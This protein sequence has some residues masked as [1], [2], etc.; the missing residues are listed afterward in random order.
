MKKVKIPIEKAIGETIPH[1]LTKIAPGEGFKGVLFKK[2]HVINKEDIPLLKSIGKNYIYKLIL[3]EDEIHEDDFAKILSEKIAGENIEYDESPSEG[4]IMFRAG[5]DGLFKLNKQRVVKLN[6]IAETS[7]PTI[8]NNFPVK[9]G[10]SVAAFRI[11]PLITKR[12]VLHKALNVVNEPLIN[13]MEYKIKKASLII[14]GTEVYEGRVKDLFKPKIERKL[15]DFSVELADS[16]IVKDNLGDIKEAFLEFTKSES[17][18]ILVSGGSSVDPDD[19]TK[20]ALKKAGVRFIREGNPIQPANNLTIGYFGE[21]TVC[22]VPAGALFY[23]ATAFDIFLPRLL[24]KDRI[25]KR[26][27]AEYSVGGLCHFCKVCVYPICP[28]GKV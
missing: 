21:I 27:I 11:I 6:M 26:D 20:K 2:G 3:D 18:L 13:V 1:D 23:K 22:V 16:I 8:H 5:K 19:L 14:T 17:E 7:F 4:K 10:Q 12:K 28:F 9:K 15:G 25:T 24:A